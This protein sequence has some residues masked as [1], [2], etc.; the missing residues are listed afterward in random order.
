MYKG[1]EIPLVPVPYSLRCSEQK[2]LAYMN[3]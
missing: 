3:D 1:C 2:W